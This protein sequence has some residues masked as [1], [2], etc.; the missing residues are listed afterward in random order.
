[1][2]SAEL[3]VETLQLGGILFE[4]RQD[5]HS[6]D[7]RGGAF[8]GEELFFQVVFAMCCCSAEAL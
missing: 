5:L 3:R 8:D 1:V 4:A 2:T 6:G 7:N